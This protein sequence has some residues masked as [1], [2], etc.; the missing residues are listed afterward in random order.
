[1][2]E[3]GLGLSLGR[4]ETEDW[5]GRY[6]GIRAGTREAS[7]LKLPGEVFSGETTPVITHKFKRVLEEIVASS[8]WGPS[9][10]V[11]GDGDR[12]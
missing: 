4:K 11:S 8:P 12:G 6:R 2:A 9:R 7:C 10:W 5:E 1:M 3:K